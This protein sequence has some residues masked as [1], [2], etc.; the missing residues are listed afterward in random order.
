MFV[1]RSLKVKRNANDDGRS[2]AAKKVKPEAEDPQL[3]AD[4]DGPADAS[5]TKEAALV[6]HH[7]AQPCPL[8]GPASQVP[9][10]G[11]AGPEQRAQD[12]DLLE[13][14]VKSFSKTQR[15]AEPGEPVC[16]VCGRYGEYICNETDEDVC[17]LE[18]KAKHLLQVRGAEGQL[19]PGGP[20]KAGSEPVAPRPAS[21][22]YTEHAF[23]SNLREDQIENLR[24][25]LGI[26]VQGP[27]V[28]RPIIDFEHCGF[29]E[30]LNLNLKT[31][32]YEVPTPIQMQMVPVGLL[33]RDVLASA[34]TGSGKTAA[35]L[36]PVI[37]RS[38]F[39]SKMPSAL[40]LTPTRELAIQIERQAKELMSGLPHMRTALLVGG[41]PAPPQLHRLRQRVQVIIATPGRLLDIIKQSAVELGGIKIVV[42][43]EADTMLKMGFQQQVLDVLEN[44]PH[45][46]QTLLASAT[47]PASIEQLASQL[48]R[49]P[50]RIIAGEKNLPCSNVRQIVLW[51]EEPAKKKKLFEILNDKKLFKPPVLVFVDCKL[52]ADLLSEAVQKITGLKST[53]VH[54]EKSQ[55]E[56]KNIL[57]GLLEGDYEVVVSTG[58]LG[59]GLD[60]VSVKLVVNFDMPSSMD[61]YVHQVGRVGR[62]GQNGTAITFINNNSKRLFWDIAKRVKPTGSLLPPQLLNSPYLHDQK[63]KEQQKDRQTQNDLVTGANLMDI[64]RKHDKSNSQK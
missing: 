31:S 14:P 37:M 50:V 38:L 36:L 60:L 47:I 34:D 16:V 10:G 8:P 1:P 22:V 58:V 35:F 61:E 57:K 12:T 26:V 43:D 62:L 44:V 41:L 32:G 29:P 24:R 11:L 53:S 55:P 21:Y 42:V 25:Q 20:Q 40:V 30:A 33:G 46:C 5:G 15:Q 7:G 6:A 54:S 2:C 23:I 63:R 28:P 13:E 9:E 51:V 4:G 48:L 39:Q 64:I 27:G 18:C 45:D 3:G 19:A 59:R 56:R 52:G 17:S 49:D